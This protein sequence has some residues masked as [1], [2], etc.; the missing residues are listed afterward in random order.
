MNKLLTNIV[1]MFLGGIFTALPLHAETYFWT[2]DHGTMN[3]T[4]D[5]SSIPQKYRK[6]SRTRE[7]I[8]SASQ[9]PRS[10]VLPDK[11]GN[12]AAVQNDRLIKVTPGQAKVEPKGFYS[13]KKGGEWASEFRTIDSEV[14]ILEQKILQ[15][16]ELL[17]KPT[18]LNKEQANRLPQD[19]VSLIEQRNDAIKRYNI[20]NEAANTAG[21][22]AEYRK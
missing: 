1:V 11:A 12:S 15:T 6:K 3:F 20:L 7:G 10:A 19:L 9:P 5:Y 18:G 4:D 8:D 13:G 2:D 17:K 21:V 22:P 14:S 16:K